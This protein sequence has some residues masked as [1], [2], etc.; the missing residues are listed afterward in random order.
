MGA[1]ILLIQMN[2]YVMLSSNMYSSLNL[3]RVSRAYRY[4][5]AWPVNFMTT[6][7]TFSFRQ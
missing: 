2:V 5:L 3:R 6:K 1:M 7:L 4:W